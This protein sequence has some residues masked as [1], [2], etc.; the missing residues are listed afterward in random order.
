MFERIDQ[1]AVE[2]GMRGAGVADGVL[3]IKADEPAGLSGMAD[4]LERMR[5]ELDQQFRDFSD[6]RDDAARRAHTDLP[7]GEAKLARAD[8][9]AA[10]EALSVTVRTLEKL[11]QLQRQIARDR[12][13]IDDQPQNRE[14]YEALLAEIEQRIEDRIAEGL[15][16][17][18]T[19]DG[20]PG[21]YPADGVFAGK[22]GDGR[23]ETR[24]PEELF[25]APV[26]EAQLPALER[27]APGAG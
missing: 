5:N 11:D 2:D 22:I 1:A 23:P 24:L 9:K 27:P 12:A 25:D 21:G 6:L 20:L 13:E 8:L 15:L 18:G 3:E 26:T 10:V 14:T 7:D 19:T 4:M 16:A 17:A